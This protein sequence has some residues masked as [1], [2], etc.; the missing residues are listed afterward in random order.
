MLKCLTLVILVSFKVNARIYVKKGI[1]DESCYA[2]L[3]RM[4][5][6][7][8]ANKIIVLFKRSRDLAVYLHSVESW[9]STSLKKKKKK[10][11]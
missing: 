2:V 11:L 6:I 8:Y 1:W 10:K 9:D 7:V 3:F 5:L 4:N